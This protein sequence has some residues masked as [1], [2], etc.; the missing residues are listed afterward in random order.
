MRQLES[1]ENEIKSFGEKE[2]PYKKAAEIFLKLYSLGDDFWKTFRYFSEK[3]KYRKVYEKQGMSKEDANSKASQTAIDI[4]HDTT[5]FYSQQ[6]KL[7]QALRKFPATGTF[8]SFPYLTMRNAFHTLIQAQKEIRNKDTYH[9]GIQRISGFG[10]AVGV[11]PTMASLATKAI[12]LSD[13]DDDELRMFMP[14]YWKNDILAFIKDNKDGTFRFNNLSYL[15]YYNSVTTPV[16]T[17]FRAS[18]TKDGITDDV[19]KEVINSF[20]EPY[21]SPDIFFDKSTDILK[22]I[23]SKTGDKIYNKTDSFHE[24]VH[25][26]GEYMWDAFEPSTITDI[27]RMYK[28]GREGGDWQSQLK[29]M[30]SGNQIRTLDIEKSYKYYLLKETD[31][32]IDDILWDYKTELNSFNKLKN[33]NKMDVSL[34]NRKKKITDEKINELVK[35]S[36]AHYEA[37][38]K[39]GVKPEVLLQIMKDRRISVAIRNA[40]IDKQ[41][42]KINDEGK[43]VNEIQTK[44]IQPTNTPLY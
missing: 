4:V 13:D 27:K 21:I 20:F 29:G 10:L 38:K 5:A 25:K 18:K 33:P 3:S 37:A 7:L 36:T 15:D 26:M 43:I 12:G 31:K 41:P 14:S 32:N 30:L 8:V 24:K 6:P 17:L 39:F 28:T 1:I 19:I 11:L 22:G 40:I 35:K 9:I 44:S 16:L 23:N 34:L 2:M 42:I